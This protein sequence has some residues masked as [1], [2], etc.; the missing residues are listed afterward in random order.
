MRR[1]SP[2][3]LLVWL[4]WI[5]RQMADEQRS[6]Y[7]EPQATNID[8]VQTFDYINRYVY[9]GK[10]KLSWFTRR[11]FSKFIKNFNLS[12]TDRQCYHVVFLLIADTERRQLKE[13]CSRVLKKNH[14]VMFNLCCP[15]NKSSLIIKWVKG[16]TCLKR[17]NSPV[18][19]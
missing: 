7:D 11:I 1:I 17:E 8:G 18:Y 14:V 9:S 15:E 16:A 5:R 10:V 12:F 19:S 6:H 4:A 13:N 2:S 3:C